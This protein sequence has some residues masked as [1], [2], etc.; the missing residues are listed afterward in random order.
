MGAR[1]RSACSTRRVAK[2]SPP[3]SPQDRRSATD[4]TRPQHDTVGPAERLEDLK[5]RHEKGLLVSIKFLK[6]FLDLARDVVKTEGDT[7]AKE[8]LDRGKTALTELF[9]EARTGDTP[10]MVRRIVDD[11]DEID[12]AVRFDGWQSTHAGER[13]VKKALRRTLFKY[14][15]HQDAELFGRAYEYI[16]LHC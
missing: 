13:E 14:K 10:V 7:P 12:R 6:E 8:D 1:V 16:R 11:I 15:L 9:E 2:R 3:P 4:A 5:K